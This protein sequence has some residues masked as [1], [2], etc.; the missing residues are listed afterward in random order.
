MSFRC[1]S[2]K[3]IKNRN[4][5]VCCGRSLEI[6]LNV[7][8]L[9]GPLKLRKETGWPWRLQWRL[10]AGRDASLGKKTEKNKKKMASIV[11]FAKQHLFNVAA[12]VIQQTIRNFLQMKKAQN[13]VRNFLKTA[14]ARSRFLKRVSSAATIQKAFRGCSKP[15]FALKKSLRNWLG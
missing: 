15:V 3:S 10:G 12:M 7:I 9:S 4:A 8:Q 13:I 6:C 2:L 11:F 5:H 14:V 1:Q